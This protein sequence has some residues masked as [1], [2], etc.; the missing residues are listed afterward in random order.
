[1][2]NSR[3]ALYSILSLIPSAT[4]EPKAPSPEPA[5]VQKNIIKPTISGGQKMEPIPNARLPTHEPAKLRVKALP[6]I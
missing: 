6:A 3:L 2:L 5:P 4:E 1:M